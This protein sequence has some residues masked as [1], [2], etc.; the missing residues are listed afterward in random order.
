M[1]IPIKTPGKL[2][3]HRLRI[4]VEDVDVLVFASG[5]QFEA[6]GREP[7]VPINRI[8]I[9]DLWPFSSILIKGLPDFLAVVSQ[10]LYG[11]TG[12]IVF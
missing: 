4:E 7:T 6:V 1:V 12:E 10:N 5:G 2:E 9:F 8:Y 11:F 3:R